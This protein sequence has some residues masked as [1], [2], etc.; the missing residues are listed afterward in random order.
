MPQGGHNGGGQTLQDLVD[1]QAN[2]AM[3]NLDKVK[4]RLCERRVSQD[5]GPR[6]LMFI[7]KLSTE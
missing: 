2:G 6:Y 1:R 7:V 5:A 4:T 3:G